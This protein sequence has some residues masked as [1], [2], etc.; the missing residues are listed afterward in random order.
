MTSIRVVMLVS[1]LVRAISARRAGRFVVEVTHEWFNWNKRVKA[2]V[3]TNLELTSKRM[4][5]EQ[6]CLLCYIPL[7]SDKCECGPRDSPKEH[8]RTCVGD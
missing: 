3:A 6:D 4:L 2:V 7:F 5:Y 8:H 1:K